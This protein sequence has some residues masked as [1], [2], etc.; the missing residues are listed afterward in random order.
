MLSD[1]EVSALD[2]P[3]R[4]FDTAREHF[5]LQRLVFLDL[6]EIINALQSFAAETLDEIVF[7]RDK[8]LRRTS[9]ALTAA[10][11]AELVIDT[12]RFVPLGAQDMQPARRDDLFLF[13]VGLF[14][15]FFVNIPV[16]FSDFLDV[17]GDVG[18]EGSGELD[19][20]G[21]HALFA[22][23]SFSQKFRVAAEQNIGTAPGHVGGW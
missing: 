11:A 2:G 23:F 4:V 6:E 10:S 9:V 16:M 19:G 12:A 22:K 13:R 15:E 14:F 5:R 3:L 17:V 21:I 20:F 1:T 18:D 7:E 8:E